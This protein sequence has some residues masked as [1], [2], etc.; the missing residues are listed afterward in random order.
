MKNITQITDKDIEKFSNGKTLKVYEM[1]DMVYF[2]LHVANDS[3]EIKNSKGRNVNE[4]DIITNSVY[5]DIARFV[6]AFDKEGAYSKYGEF[7]AGFFYLPVHKTKS[8]SYYNIEE[9]T[10]ILS[11]YYVENRSFRDDNNFHLFVG[12]GFKFI[13]G[14]NGGIGPY[15]GEISLGDWFNKYDDPT[16]LIYEIFKRIGVDVSVSGNEMIDIEGIVLK[17]G[18]SSYKIMVN[19]TYPHIEASSKLIYRDTLLESFIHTIT[20]EKRNE[21]LNSNKDFKDKIYDFFLEYVDNTDFFTTMWFD[22]DDFLPPTEGYIGDIAYDMI[23]PIVAI[24]CRKNPVYKNV[25][26]VLLVTFSGSPYAN[27]FKRFKPEDRAILTE[28]LAKSQINIK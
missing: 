12:K 26:R 7:T 23:P 14:W 27:K 16:S 8:I 17:N 18:N 2:K 22:E 15:I 4:I 1:L 10:F 19:D 3:Y 11:D 6:D 9:K 20:D 21:I 13:S 25:L 5:R 28:I 24:V